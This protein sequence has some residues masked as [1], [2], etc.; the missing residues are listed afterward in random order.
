MVITLAE[1]YNALRYQ[2]HAGFKNMALLKNRSLIPNVA[3]LFMLNMVSL[4]TY[5]IYSTIKTPGLVCGV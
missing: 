5:H 4:Y 2:G 1:I 3:S